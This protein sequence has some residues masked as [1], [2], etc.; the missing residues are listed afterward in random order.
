MYYTVSRN[1]DFGQGFG[2]AQQHRLFLFLSFPK[3]YR[4]TFDIISSKAVPYV[5]DGPYSLFCKLSRFAALFFALDRFGLGWDQT[6]QLDNDGRGGQ[7]A[8]LCR[9]NLPNL[10][11]DFSETIQDSIVC[12]LTHL[13]CPSAN[14]FR[15][16]SPIVV[17]V[18]FC[19]FLIRDQIQRH[20]YSSEAAVA[21]VR[22]R[23]LRKKMNVCLI[24]W[25]NRKR[26]ALVSR[27]LIDGSPSKV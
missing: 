18:F 24:S 4:P 23:I 6:F 3:S 27:L 2:W 11:F 21:K 15:A 8:R 5:V 19:F 10:N 9:P 25:R 20:A 13:S 7:E 22:E 26:T 17:M 16:L 14:V 12:H 1:L